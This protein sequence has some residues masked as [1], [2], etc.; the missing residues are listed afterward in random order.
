V[1]QNLSRRMLSF[2]ASDLEMDVQVLVDVPHVKGNRIHTDT[3]LGRSGLVVVAFD[4]VVSVMQKTELLEGPSLAVSDKARTSAVAS[5]MQT[6][7]LTE[8]P[9]A[10][11]GRLDRR[12]GPPHLPVARGWPSSE[13]PQCQPRS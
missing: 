6:R 13:W 8:L 12:E 10:K 4:L 3:K 1:V 7:R 9:Q 5:P 2:V 11:G